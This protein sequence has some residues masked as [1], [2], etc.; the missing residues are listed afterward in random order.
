MLE[1]DFSSKDH[2]ALLNEKHFYF[3]NSSRI[4]AQ[5]KIQENRRKLF[6]KME[7]EWTNNLQLPRA[8]LLWPEMFNFIKIYF[9]SQTSLKKDR[10]GLF[11]SRFCHFLVRL[12]PF[13]DIFGLSYKFTHTIK[14]GLLTPSLT[15]FLNLNFSLAVLLGTEVL[16]RH[17]FLPLNCGNF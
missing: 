7:I 14:R 5:D 1:D 6:V 12:T 10:S 15:F 16:G 13:H 9:V 2:R 8:A 3:L 17:I 11:L 4:Y